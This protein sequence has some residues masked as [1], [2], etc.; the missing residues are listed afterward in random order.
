M[1][2]M[3]SY[4]DYAFCRRFWA[5]FGCDP[6]TCN[7]IG[8]LFP[9]VSHFSPPVD[10]LPILTGPLEM[11]LLTWTGMIMFLDGLLYCITFLPLKT[12]AVLWDMCVAYR[13]KP[14]SLYPKQLYVLVQV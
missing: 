4:R 6:F 10:L 7:K 1:N 14:V 11:E 12:I 13:H 5:Y 8:N 3:F 9:Q 2:A